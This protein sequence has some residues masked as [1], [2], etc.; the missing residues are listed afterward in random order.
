M[1]PETNTNS[2]LDLHSTREDKSEENKG[3]YWIFNLKS[4]KI[5]AGKKKKELTALWNAPNIETMGRTHNTRDE[6]LQ[7]GQ[8]TQTK[9]YKI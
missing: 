4:L 1:A 3:N 7:K 8:H 9:I 2:L 6:R 5:M